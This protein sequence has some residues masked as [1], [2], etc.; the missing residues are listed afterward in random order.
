[1]AIGA[2]AGLCL[3]PAAAAIAQTALN[4]SADDAKRVAALTA[5][6]RRIEGTDVIVFHPASLLPS[7]ADRLLR[8]L[9]RGVPAL[10]KR[11]G[12][13]DWQAVPAGRITYY[14]SDDTFVSHAS[15]RGAVFIPM[16]RVMDGR[17]PY[18][19]EAAHELLASTRR[20]GSSGADAG[21]VR[22]PLW[23]TEGLADYVAQLVVTDTGITETG[24]FAVWRSTRRRCD[25]RRAG[26]DA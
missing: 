16:A 2:L 22:R 26:Q 1:M 19:H 7:N 20:G 3:L 18:F 21:A 9:D 6:G 12:V 25:L 4:W 15:G 13:H 24:P 8:L 14:L 5:S 11:V 17:A 23:L 10:R